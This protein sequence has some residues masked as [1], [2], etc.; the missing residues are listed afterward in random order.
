MQCLL[1]LGEK[2]ED[3]SSCHSGAVLCSLCSCWSDGGCHHSDVRDGVVLRDDL[4]YVCLD[5]LTKKGDEFT[6]SLFSVHDQ[7]EMGDDAGDNFETALDLYVSCSYYGLSDV[8]A[9]FEQH[10]KGSVSIIHVNIV[11]LSK[12]LYKLENF[13]T[14]VVYAPDIIAINETRI[15]YSVPNIYYVNLQGY[16]FIHADT[17]KNAG[18]VGLYVKNCTDIIILNKRQIKNCDCETLWVEIKLNNKKYAVGVIYR[19][20][21]PSFK[22]FSE[23]LFSFLH[24]LN[25]QKYVYFV[26]GD[27]NINL[28]HY[29]KVKC[30]TD[31]VDILHS[32]SCKLLIDKPTRIT[33]HS[34]TLVG[35][36]VVGYCRGPY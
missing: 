14:Q 18:G 25:D 30:V 29:S 33:K 16:K 19:H 27:F 22:T 13:L 26:C 10:C 36:E 31:Y 28:M 23:E 32:L 21:D 5:C 12:N 2:C 7:G 20:P 3:Y 1:C 24:K 15:K 6:D 35:S 11:S 4:S 9:A 34:T 8:V 17:H